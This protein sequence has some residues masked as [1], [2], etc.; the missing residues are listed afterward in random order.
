[1]KL[2]TTTQIKSLDTYTI[3]NEPIAS[4]DL[5]ERAANAIT[6]YLLRFFGETKKLTVIAGTG[7]NGG[8]GLATARLLAVCGFEVE[9][10]LVNPTGKLSNDCT[11]NLE[12]LQKQKTVSIST[13][14][15]IETLPDITSDYIIDALFGSGL[16]RPLEGLFAD[17]VKKINSAGIPV[18]SIDIPSGL[19]GEDNTHNN[20]ENIVKATYTITLQFPKIAFLLPEN[21]LFIGKWK[22][23]DIGLHPE[24][25]QQTQTNF[26][27]TNYTTLPPLKQRGKFTH[28][29][30]YGHALF[31]GGSYGK[32]GAAVLSAKAC[33]RSGVG[34][35]TAHC[36]ECGVS[37]LQTAVPEA[38]CL[39]DKAH[40]T[41]SLLPE[42][43]SPYSAIGIGCG[44]GT[45]PDSS[46]VL[47][48]L[49][50]QATQPLVL[51]ADAINIL[52]KHPEWI[53]L[54][55][56]NT[57]ITPHPKEFE[58][59]SGP[60]KNRYEQIQKAQDFSQKHH[61]FV[62]LKG[63]HTAIVCPNGEVHF[64]T[65]GNPGM[66][67]A[68]SGDVLCGMILSLLAQGYEP[69]ESALFGVFLHGKAGDKA[70]EINGQTA[71]IAGD[72]IDA[73]RLIY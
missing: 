18:I 64:N 51:D 16:N 48:R 59:L 52:S 68:G 70:A 28:K 37:V 73:L 6:E 36:P 17:I 13:I 23:V 67:T 58:R 2:F 50:E 41:I 8:D 46:K 72:I 45:E 3:A 42:N 33:L 38:M 34:L 43:L 7:N 44:L 21:D 27:L 69:K 10:L 47:M 31:I 19:F 24:A 57:I 71:M 29:G 11:I 22:I 25:I 53:N 32:M 39:P 4:I 5:M 56:K 61:I 66:A 65:N 26:F 54:L 20:S 60:Y 55:P 35:L 49:M 9:V 40:S 30:A 14:E 15:S 1:M 12:R 63:A 62:V